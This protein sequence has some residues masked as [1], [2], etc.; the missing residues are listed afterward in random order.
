TEIVKVKTQDVLLFTSPSVKQSIQ[1]KVQ[2]FFW[3]EKNKI[4][5][6]LNTKD[7]VEFE[8]QVLFEI[9]S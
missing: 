1:C 7:L 2:T 6:Y 9:H 3:L 8:K 4:V 5:L